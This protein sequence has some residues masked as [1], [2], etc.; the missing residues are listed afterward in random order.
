M[1]R[2][3]DLLETILQKTREDKLEWKEYSIGSY[4]AAVGP[5][6]IIV[7][8]TNIMLVNERGATI[9][10]ILADGRN[11]ASLEEIHK[12]ARHRALRVDETLASIRNTLERL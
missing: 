3:L 1:E 4:I 12:L 10:V 8:R 9:D 6:S 11:N 7:D 5:N 2:S